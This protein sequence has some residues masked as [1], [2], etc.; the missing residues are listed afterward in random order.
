M[1]KLAEIIVRE[2][3]ASGPISFRKFMEMALFC[4][5]YGYYEKEEDNIGPPG[6]F[7]TS[8][9]SGPLFG[10]L[11]AYRYAK[12]LKIIIGSDS[13]PDT[14]LSLVEAGAHHGALA[15]DI[16]SR[17]R[18]REPALFA[19]LE[20]V[21]IE[22]SP[23]R[24]DAQQARLREFPQVLWLADWTAA[25]AS[26][27]GG[28]RGIIFS[29]ELLDAMPVYRL[30]WNAAKG[31]WFE[32]GVDFRHDRL[33][34]TTLEA[35]PPPGAIPDVSP[36]LLEVLPDGFTTETCPAATGW[37]GDAAATLARGVLLT[38]DYGLDALDF[39][40]PGRSEGT[41][42]A[43]HRHQVSTDVLSQPGEQDITAHVNFEAIQAAGEKAGLR[44][45]SYQ[46]QAQ[47]LTRI[48]LEL[49][50]DSESGEFWNSSQIGQFKRLTHP[51]HLGRAF[52]V[53]V[54]GRNF[55]DAPALE[56]VAAH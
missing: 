21:I 11:L 25:G 2:I 12:W 47:F 51:E 37:W 30:R 54:Q 33:A 52:R 48:A 42:R 45:L 6:D 16:L 24:R 3:R 9:S 28:I 43:Y 55:Q 7:Y 38:C 40:A 8:V 4:P 50:K 44:T 17:L 15:A 36:A 29:N 23:V 41:L 34:W 39:F 14:P 5:V 13:K 49:W 53:L 56:S 31:A 32:C 18:T 20:Y 1:N 10:H 27:P 46:P 22:P 26:Y 35:I 19:R